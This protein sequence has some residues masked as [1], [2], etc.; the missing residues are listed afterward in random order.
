MFKNHKF[1]KSHVEKSH[2]EKSHVE[3]SQFSESITVP[4]SKLWNMACVANLLKSTKTTLTKKKKIQ[5]SGR[6]CQTQDSTRSRVYDAE[7]KY[8]HNFSTLLIP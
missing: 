1:K 2:F 5:D 7:I 3:K 6:A 8:Y 4:I